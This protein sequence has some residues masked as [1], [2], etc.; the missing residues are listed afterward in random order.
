MEALLP[1][2]RSE[3]W[4]A[5]WTVHDQDAPEH[6]VWRVTYG[7]VFV[8]AT[9]NRRSNNLEDTPTRL[10]Q[11]LCEI[12]SFSGRNKCGEFTQCFADALDTLGSGGQHVHGY[13]KDLCPD[14]Q[15][16]D[17]AWTILDACQKE[18]VFGGMG[19]WNDMGLEGTD[20]KEY[21]RVSEKL[22]HTL[23][24][25]ISDAVTHS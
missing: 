10:K 3:F 15:T 24:Q 18:W 13:H 16:S 4:I 5:R 8:G 22:F 1:M 19:S 23:N 25:A 12:H 6:R 9:A 7:R 2:N 11:A 20:Q 17:Q 14:A 21:E